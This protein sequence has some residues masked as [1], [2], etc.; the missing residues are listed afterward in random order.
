L[1]VAGFIL[2]VAGLSEGGVNLQPGT[3][4][5]ERLAK[6]T[7]G[8]GRAALRQLRLGPKPQEAGL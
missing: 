1:A 8:C 5:L 3:C 6:N 4:N 2:Q 7:F